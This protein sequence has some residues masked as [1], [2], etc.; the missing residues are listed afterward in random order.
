MDQQQFEEVANKFVSDVKDTLIAKGDEYVPGEQL[1]RFHN[2]EAA[3]HIVQGSRQQALWGFLAK[4]LISI[5]DMVQ[6]EPTKHSMAKW[7][8]KLGDAMAYLILLHAMVTESHEDGAMAEQFQG[9]LA[10]EGISRE[11]RRNLLNETKVDP[12]HTEVYTSDTGL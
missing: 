12:H 9:L 11:D 1:S 7:E 6:D 4:H 8:E 3:A 10:S 5:S 2:F